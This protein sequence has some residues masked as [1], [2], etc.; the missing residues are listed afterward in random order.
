AAHTLREEEE[1]ERAPEDDPEE[2]RL[3]GRRRRDA[4]ADAAQHRGGCGTGMQ[5][6]VSE[7]YARRQSLREDQFEKRE[8]KRGSRDQREEN[9]G[10]L[11]DGS[12]DSAAARIAGARREAPDA[13]RRAMDVMRILDSRVEDH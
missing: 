13:V 2:R 10:H 1:Q 8:E 11:E 9:D 12:K 7:R 3:F 5:E 4:V 6:R